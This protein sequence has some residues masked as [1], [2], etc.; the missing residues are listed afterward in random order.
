MNTPNFSMDNLKDLTV[1]AKILESLF[2]INFI[3]LTV[4]GCTANE[5]IGDV[6]NKYIKSEEKMDANKISELLVNQLDEILNFT[7]VNIGEKFK[8]YKFNYDLLHYDSS[9][10]NSYKIIFLLNLISETYSNDLKD[11][12][13]NK[14]INMIRYHIDHRVPKAEKKSLFYNE[15]G[16]KTIP[17]KTEIKDHKKRVRFLNSYFDV[18]KDNEFNT[19]YYI[20]K[21]NM[22]FETFVNML[23]QPFNLKL[24]DEKDNQPKSSSSWLTKDELSKHF[25]LSNEKAVREKLMK[26]WNWILYSK[27]ELLLDDINSSSYINTW[28]TLEQI[29]K[30]KLQE[31]GLSKQDMESMRKEQGFLSKLINLSFDKGI[32]KNKDDFN[33][34]KHI[35]ANRNKAQHDG[36]SDKLNPDYETLIRKLLEKISKE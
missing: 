14:A 34:C 19:K 17:W 28:R 12:E 18:F 23:N 30:N 16:K 3:Y 20:K 25:T 4:L 24:L 5:F 2:K 26:S 36:A 1:I 9:K 35:L 31:Q 6:I 10:T 11:I 32:I 8:N 33:L 21:D 29:L 13:Y 7:D 15:D 22:T 27:Y